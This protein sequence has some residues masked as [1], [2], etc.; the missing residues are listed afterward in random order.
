MLM[1]SPTGEIA[2]HQII[3]S[4]MRQAQKQI[5]GLLLHSLFYAYHMYVCVCIL[6]TFEYIISIAF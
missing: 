6:Y 5:H 3:V 4:G 2:D 1:S